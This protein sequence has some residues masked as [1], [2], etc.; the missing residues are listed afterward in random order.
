MSSDLATRWPAERMIAAVAASPAAVTVHDKATWLGLFTDD[1]EIHDPVGSRPHG[2]PQARDRFY[3]TF[4]A[5]NDIRFD[6]E[7][8]VAQGDVVV[9]DLVIA[10]RMSTGLQVDV[11]THIRYQL[12]EQDGELKVHRLYAHWELRPMVFKTLGTGLLGWRTYLKLS[13]HMLRCQ[14]L[15]GVFGFMR[16]FR[17]AGQRGRDAAEQF[18]VGH[19]LDWSKLNLGGDQATATIRQ[20]ARRGVCWMRFDAR[21]AVVEHCFYWNSDSA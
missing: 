9:R 11:P 2:T 12:V 8:D 1:A 14:G 7:H 5:P 10:T 15:G 6:V 18:L 4:I 3:D 17:T 13:A 20:Q 16:G 21:G 19:D